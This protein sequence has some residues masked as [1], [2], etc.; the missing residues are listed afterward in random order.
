MLHMAESVWRKD[1][2]AS[3]I[4]PKHD[5]EKEAVEKSKSSDKQG[6]LLS[7]DA[8]FAQTGNDQQLSHP[9]TEQVLLAAR[10]AKRVK[11]LR[12]EVGFKVSDLEHLANSHVPSFRCPVST[13]T[14]HGL[15]AEAVNI[16]EPSAFGTRFA[17]SF[18]HCG[19]HRSK[20]TR[21]EMLHVGLFIRPDHKDVIKDGRVTYDTADLWTPHRLWSPGNRKQW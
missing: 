11:L 10:G 18:S 14:R 2:T 21:G 4:H 16:L 7:P 19:A 9:W 3:I 12:P 5:G 20:S 8:G 13:S 17:R 1:R 6:S 15:N